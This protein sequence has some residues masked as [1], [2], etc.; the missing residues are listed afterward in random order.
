MYPGAAGHRQIPGG[1]AHPADVAGFQTREFEDGFH[2]LIRR[3]EVVLDTGEAFLLH[4]VPHGAVD[5]D[6]RRGIVAVEYA[7]KYA[8]ARVADS[9]GGL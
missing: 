4:N 5:E 2:S 8:A 7:D 6:G 1:E 3:S 9:T